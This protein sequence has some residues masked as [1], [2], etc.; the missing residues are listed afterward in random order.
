M[1]AMTLFPDDNALDDA[2]LWAVID[3]AVVS[4][5]AS[6]SNQ[7]KSLA[8]MGNPTNHY[9][10]T[11]KT[12]TIP[13]ISC[14]YQ[15]PEAKGSRNSRFNYTMEEDPREGEVLQE[16][17]IPHRPHKMLR[18]DAYESLGLQGGGGERKGGQKARILSG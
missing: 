7:S 18:S 2:E 8:L 15:M 11:P 9:N 16:Q 13:S 3:S 6:K 12:C 10:L 5:S 14:R 17:S 4:H 1:V